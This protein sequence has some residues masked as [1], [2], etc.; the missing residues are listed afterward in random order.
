M[1][2]V[3]GALVLST[4]KKPAASTATPTVGAATPTVRVAA[5]A[6]PATPA[7]A[8]P[9]AVAAAT[10]VATVAPTAT[11]APPTPTPIP[12]TPTP[13][14]GTFGALPPADMPSGNSAGRSLDFQFRLDMS[15]Q[16]VPSQAPVFK[17]QH[18]TWTAAQAG[19][20]ADSLG[21]GGTPTDQGNG[22][23][24]VSGKGS[25]YVANDL[26]QYAAAT[27]ATPVP[28]PLPTSDILV[29]EARSWLLSHAIVGAEA[30]PGTVAS[31]NATLGRATVLI[32]PVQ[33]APILSQIPSASIT[34]DAAGDVLE[35]NVQWPAAMTQSTY[36]LRGASALW[37]DVQSGRGYVEVDPSLLPSGAVQGTVTLTS[38]GLAYTTASSPNG[39]QYLVPLVVFSG[40]SNISGASQPV[41]VK[42]YVAAAGA[43]SAPRG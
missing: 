14:V 23:F 30:G 27:T 32:K 22:S 9:L 34:L 15:L 18:R 26:I 29:Q 36:G 11:K 40:T 43:Q 10:R 7:K 13:I 42:V 25:L 17:F 37:S 5:A 19:A 8:T 2:A 3:V 1:A 16:D 35:A 41:P 33:P 4:S 31:S 12:P 21:I 38:A 39:N 28:G 20:L 24:Q 6:T